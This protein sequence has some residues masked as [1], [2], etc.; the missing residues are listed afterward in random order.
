MTVARY[1][2]ITESIVRPRSAM[3]R[4]SR[5][6]NRVSSSVSTKTLMSISARSAASVK[7]RMPSTMIARRGATGL[8]RRPAGVAGEVVERRL[9]GAPALQLVDV[10]DHQV[11]LERIGMVV[12]ERGAL[13][14]PQVVAIAIVAVVLE[15]GDARRGRALST[16]RRTTVVLP[17][18]DPPA[19]PMTR[20]LC[21]AGSWSEAGVSFAES[22]AVSG[23]LAPYHD[24]GGTSHVTTFHRDSA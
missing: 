6:M 2:S 10:P 4:C 12:V 13:L 24:A 19:T 7:I 14:E 15:H 22:P 18:P 5:R 1:C 9:D 3:S 21:L 23:T 8:G 17:E 20:R 16:M 11:G